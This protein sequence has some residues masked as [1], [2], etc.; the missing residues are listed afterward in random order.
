MSLIGSSTVAALAEC[1]SI[2]EVERTCVPDLWGEGLVLVRSAGGAFK[3]RFFEVFDAVGWTSSRK[4]I[5][6]T[7]EVARETFRTFQNVL[8]HPTE[9]T[10][11]PFS[12]LLALSFDER[13]QQKCSRVHRLLTGE[14]AL[15]CFD[16][17]LRVIG[18]HIVCSITA[19]S[20]PWE[21][22]GNI[23]RREAMRAAQEKAFRQWIDELQRWKLL[24]SPLLMLSVCESAAVRSLENQNTTRT[25]FRLLFELHKSGL[26]WLTESDDGAVIDRTASLGP[27]IT[28][29]QFPEGINAEA[30]EDPSSPDSMIMISSAPL[31]LGIWMNYMAASQPSL[32]LKLM[33]RQSLMVD[34]LRLPFSA[35]SWEKPGISTDRDRCLVD[36]IADVCAGILGSGRTP[37]LDFD[38][39]FVTVHFKICLLQ[40][41]E[42]NCPFTCLPAIELFISSAC[43]RDGERIRA[44]LERSGFW[45]S[46]TVEVYRRILS[47]FSFGITDEQVK[48][49]IRRFDLPKELFSVVL[50]WVREAKDYAK[51]A[52]R[53]IRESNFLTSAT[54]E[55]IAKTVLQLQRRDGFVALLP[56]DLSE[57]IMREAS[58]K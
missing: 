42:D 35:F 34:R 28:S 21:A 32:S 53:T 29:V 46:R 33:A 27:K 16:E 30:Y 15:F 12:E 18:A 51:A 54:L 24:L 22:L 56:A 25:A 3:T 26:K 52:L 50:P 23:A 13:W 9:E 6:K 11:L 40:S 49:T 47:D 57:R 45:K 14:R 43:Q 58:A 5:Q 2:E 36:G 7:L 41:L 31:Y 39:L 38:K 20:I 17:A 8:L 4:R 48:E 44:V 19:V 37:S 1:S 55:S 10:V